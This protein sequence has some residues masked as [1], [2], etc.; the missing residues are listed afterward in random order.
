MTTS[1]PGRFHRWRA[2]WFGERD[3]VDEQLRDIGRQG[4]G[5]S[6]IAH[7]ASLLLLLVFSGGSLVTLSGD[8]LVRTLKLGLTPES[9]PFAL[10]VIVSTLLV[11]A[12]D[13]AMFYAALMLRLLNTRRADLS[14]KW[15]HI[16][17]IGAATIFEAGTY[18]YM[19]WQFD[20]P[21]TWVAWAFIIGRGLAAPMFAVYLSMAR[22]IPVTAR[23]ILAQVELAS[24][25][26]LI[27][28]T[29]NVANDQTAT[30]EQKAGLYAAV[31]VVSPSERER[32]DA[33]MDAVSART[34]FNTSPFGVSEWGQPFA[35]PASSSRPPGEGG[36]D[37]TPK[38]S[39]RLVGKPTPTTPRRRRRGKRGVR[40]V[41]SYEQDA[42]K[43]WGM[44]A[45]SVSKMQAAIPGMSRSTAG[46]WVRTLKERQ[47]AYDSQHSEQE[48]VAI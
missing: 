4:A 26:E 15:M 20:K 43:A 16:A 36:A 46:A 34:Y 13:V 2:T 44:G 31:A 28:D 29:V 19:A 27:R 5:M 17:I 1:T 39:L 23:D 30:L 18:I 38:S 35:T 12:M 10:T 25:R 14:E 40:T 11:F 47:A 37:P 8:A 45:R 3:V 21:S 22:T 6:H 32:L 33:M 42:V 7:L 41:E 24:G 48:A 9:I